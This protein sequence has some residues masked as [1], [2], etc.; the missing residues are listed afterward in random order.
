MAR[1]E[2]DL[3]RRPSAIREL[4]DH[5]DFK[6]R[7]VAVLKHACIRRLGI[8]PQVVDNE[9]LEQ[10]PEQVGVSETMEKAWGGRERRR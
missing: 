4:D 9:R 8:D 10:E 1:A 5:V 3:E 6:S 7:V 2:L